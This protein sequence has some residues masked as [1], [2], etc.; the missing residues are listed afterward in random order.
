MSKGDQRACVAHLGFVLHQR[1]QEE[2]NSDEDTTSKDTDVPSRFLLRKIELFLKKDGGIIKE[3]VE[4]RK[5]AERFLE[6]MQVEAGL[7]V[8]RGT[9][10]NDEKLYGFVHR[11]FQEYFAA[12]DVYKRSVEEERPKIINDF[13]VQHLHDPHWQEVI[14]L[15]LGKLVRKTLT[16]RLQ[17]IL[18]GKIVSRRSQ[19]TD[20][21][22]QDL[23][24]ISICLEEELEVETNLAETVVERLVTLVKTSPFSSQRSDSLRHLATLLRSRQYDVIAQKALMPLVTKETT[25]DIQIVINV[26]TIL[27]VNGSIAVKEQ[28]VQMSTDI[29]RSDVAVE[30]VVQVV[31]VAQSL[32]LSSPADSE[33]HRFAVSLLMQLAQRAD[34]SVEQI[35]QV[36]RTFDRS[37]SEIPLRRVAAQLYVSLIQ[38]ERLAVEKR[39][40]V[41]EAL[42]DLVPQFD[43]LLTE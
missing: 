25:L 21:L 10:E 6:L 7:I 38:Q 3:V 37:W 43:K 27:Y 42:R 24:F 5:E 36:A 32:Y 2:N 40:N 29:V 34:L 16:A 31:Q 1:S 20:I 22:Q 30:Q 4:Q 23:F 9:G 39:N 19:H 18:D 15:L 17:Q 11:T 41:Y 33:E 14:L 8:E 35:L 13:L 26:L 12:I 28:V